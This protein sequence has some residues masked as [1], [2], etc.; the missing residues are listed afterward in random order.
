MADGNRLNTAEFEVFFLFPTAAPKPRAGQRLRAPPVADTASR[1]WRS[2]RN[3]ASESEHRPFRA[4]QAGL[5]SN[6]E[7]FCPCHRKSLETAG[8]QG[9]FFALLRTAHGLL[10]RIS[11]RKNGANFP[12]GGIRSQRF[13]LHH[14]Q[15]SIKILAPAEVQ[16][17]HSLF[18][19]A[20]ILTET[21]EEDIILESSCIHIQYFKQLF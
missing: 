20:Q 7:P 17:E 9:F 21:Q 5:R 12:S 6:F 8:F 4:P 18:S 10:C 16:S 1:G 14:H 15:N 11:M 2:G 19:A 3:G 13:R